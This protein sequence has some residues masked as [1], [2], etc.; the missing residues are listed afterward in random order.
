[1]KNKKW[2]VIGALCVSVCAILNGC[3]GSS[4]VEKQVL[5]KDSRYDGNG[6]LEGWS[7]FVYD[8]NGNKV[9]WKTYDENELYHWSE[10][11]YGENGNII[12]CKRYYAD[13]ELFLEEI[14]N[15]NGERISSVDFSEGKEYSKSIYTYDQNGNCIKTE[16][17]VSYTHLTLPTIA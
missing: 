6:E 7:E 8:E 2:L 1:M 3:G 12:D 13:G 17:S 5:V 16:S 15:E 9:E 11:V 4:K 10:F 14:Y